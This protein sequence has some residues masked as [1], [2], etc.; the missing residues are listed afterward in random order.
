MSTERD[1]LAE[2]LQDNITDSLPIDPSRAEVQQQV[3]TAVE[4]LIAAG[5]RKVVK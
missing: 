2:L 5:Y 3:D 4:V 1:E